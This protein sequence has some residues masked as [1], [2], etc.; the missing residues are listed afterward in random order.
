MC[1]NRVHHE[2]DTAPSRIPASLSALAAEPKPSMWSAASSATILWRALARRPIWMWW[3]TTA[4]WPL[5]GVWP[6]DWGGPI[7]PW[8]RPRCGQ[9]GLHGDQRHWSVTS[10]LCAGAAS[11]RTS[12]PGISP[13]TPWRAAGRAGAR[14]IGRSQRRSAGLQRLLLRRVT[15]MSL[16]EDAVRLLR[17]VRFVVQLDFT[18]EEETLLQVMRMGDTVRLVTP[19]RVREE[20]WKM[21]LSPRPDDAMDMLHRFG[22]FHPVLPEVAD[23]DGVAQSTPHV[24]DVYRHTLRPCALPLPCA[25]GSEAVQTAKRRCRRRAWQVG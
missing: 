11:K 13:S 5:P 1:Y 18:I 7:T 12:W 15:P 17:A 10:Q 14:R 6:I 2:L 21:S 22:L 25:I 16:A 9:G 19:E 3:W 23:M 4:R 24:Y 20:L 8:T